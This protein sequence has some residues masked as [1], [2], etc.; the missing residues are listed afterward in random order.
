MQGK[1]QVVFRRPMHLFLGM[2]LLTAFLIGQ[3]A[4]SQKGAAK[5]AQN[6]VRNVDPFIGVDWA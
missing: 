6:F 3:T 2:L 5:A 1:V 4:R